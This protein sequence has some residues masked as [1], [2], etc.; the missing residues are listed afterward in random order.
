MSQEIEVK[1]KLRTDKIASHTHFM[2][3]QEIKQIFNP[4]LLITSS[5]YGRSREN[6]KL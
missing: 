5:P 1:Q 6:T 4:N 3:N 2:S